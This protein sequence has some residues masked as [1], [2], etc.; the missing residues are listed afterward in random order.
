VWPADADDEKFPEELGDAAFQG[1]NGKIIFDAD[2]TSIQP[3][4]YGELCVK[5][6]FI[7]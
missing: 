5:S 3:K 4:Q 6:I 2:S 1:N 7:R